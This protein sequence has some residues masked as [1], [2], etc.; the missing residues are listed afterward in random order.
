MS[1]FPI[2]R[3][4]NYVNILL[5]Q[6]LR[7]VTHHINSH[8]AH[9][10]QIRDMIINQLAPIQHVNALDKLLAEALASVIKEKL[11]VKT[12]QKIEERLQQRYSLDVIS[13]IKEF[14]T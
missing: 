7:K 3:I 1:E 12:Y 4:Y 13:A 14:H 2:C 10:S 8:E 6:L 11:G 9:N 5:I